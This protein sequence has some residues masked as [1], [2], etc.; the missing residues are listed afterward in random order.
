M[1]NKERKRY[2]KERSRERLVEV[3]QVGLEQVGEQGE[4]MLGEQSTN[5]GLQA[6][7]VGL[8]NSEDEVGDL[9]RLYWGTG[10]LRT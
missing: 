9:G 6:G 4:G 3:G 7:M 10:A 5:K 8:S 1:I 2:R